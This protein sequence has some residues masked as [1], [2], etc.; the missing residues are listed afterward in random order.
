MIIGRT[1][2]KRQSV[3]FKYIISLPFSSLIQPVASRKISDGPFI[4]A[5][6]NHL[7]TWQKALDIILY[8]YRVMPHITKLS[9]LPHSSFLESRL[10]VFF[11]HRLPFCLQHI[12]VGNNKER[13]FLPSPSLSNKRTDYMPSAKIVYSNRFI[14]MHVYITSLSSSHRH[15]EIKFGIL[16]FFLFFFFVCIFVFFFSLILTQFTCILSQIILFSLARILV[17]SLIVSYSLKRI[18]DVDK[19]RSM[20]ETEKIGASSHE[21]ISFDLK[22][23]FSPRSSIERFIDTLHIRLFGL[24][25]SYYRIVIVIIV[26]CRLFPSRLMIS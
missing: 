2:K 6:A 16:F 8:L 22:A 21:E 1:R 17:C 12:C 10:P 3:T 18:K 23:R 13:V 7:V 4:P 24:I 26:V 25:P 15:A 11:S 19:E 14:N 5:E 9:L 20:I